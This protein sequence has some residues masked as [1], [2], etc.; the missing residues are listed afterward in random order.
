MRW[1]NVVDAA[2]GGYLG[3]YLLRSVND[4]TT[5]VLITL[6][7][8]TGG[9]ATAEALHVSAPI[10]AVVAGLVIGNQGRRHAMSDESR[11]HIDLFWKLTDEILNA[12]LFVMI[13]LTLMVVPVGAGVAG[14]AALAILIAFGAPAVSVA[15]ALVAIRPFGAHPRHSVKILTWGALRGG[16][17]IAM[18]LALPPSGARNVIIVMTYAVVAFS[19]V[20][21]GLTFEPLLRRL[22]IGEPRRRDRGPSPAAAR[23]QPP[24]GAGPG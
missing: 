1:P 8:V 6:A 10:A 11:L 16:L 14:A 5:E 12:V 22:G 18:A 21:Q 15:V 23:R 7:L 3:F 24:A 2:D 13:G 20:F 4:Y 19:M 9:Y 17:S